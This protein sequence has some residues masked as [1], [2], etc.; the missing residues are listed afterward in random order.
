MW[1][2]FTK[3]SPAYFF[4]PFYMKNKKKSKNLQNEEISFVK[5]D[6]LCSLNNGNNRTQIFKKTFLC[7]REFSPKPLC[8]ISRLKQYL[9]VSYRCLKFQNYHFLAS[10]LIMTS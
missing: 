10:L 5:V 3:F 8:P 4:G 9:L 1:T 7:G 6:F 2:N